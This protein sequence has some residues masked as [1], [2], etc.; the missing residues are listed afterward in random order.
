M[1]FRLM[2]T[3][4][5][6]SCIGNVAWTTAMGQAA[7][8]QAAA[9][10][11][12][13]NKGE[14]PAQ[15]IAKLGMPKEKEAQVMQA[16]NEYQKKMD[17]WRATMAQKGAQIQKRVDETKNGTDQKARAEARAAQDAYNRA[18]PTAE[19]RDQTI[20]PLMSAEEYGQYRSLVYP[21]RPLPIETFSD[22]KIEVLSQGIEA[23]AVKIQEHPDELTDWRFAMVDGFTAATRT[24]SVDELGVFLGTSTKKQELKQRTPGPL[25]TG[26][27]KRINS[28]MKKIQEELAKS[29]TTA[30][31]R[32]ILGKMIPQLTGGPMNDFKLVLAEEIVNAKR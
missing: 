18:R 15:A 3:L 5:L 24:L 13:P 1:N 21:G 12:D 10:P 22:S 2:L 19:R 25:T 20:A 23:T 14:S 9:K 28:D 16:L 27:I 29:E 31:R 8:T 30:K 7:G 17:E 32:E 26:Q 4:V 11:T 6:A